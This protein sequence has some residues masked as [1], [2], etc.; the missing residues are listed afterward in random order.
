MR[1]VEISLKE[2]LVYILYKWIPIL[3][4]GVIIASFIGGYI[5]LKI[6][7][8]EALERIKEDNQKIVAENEAEILATNAKIAELEQYIKNIQSLSSFSNKKIAKVVADVSFDPITT[9]IARIR[10]GYTSLFRSMNLQ[11]TLSGLIPAD[12]SDDHLRLLIKVSIKSDAKSPNI[13][14]ITSLGGDGFDAQAVVEKVFEYFTQ[15]HADRLNTNGEHSLTISNISL[16]DAKDKQTLFDDEIKK[17]QNTINELKGAVSYYK[18]IIKETRQ[19]EGTS[20]SSLFKPVTFGFVLGI[21]LGIV[22]VALTYVIRL[23]LVI[24]EQVQERLK[25]RYIGGL[26]YRPALTIGKLAEVAA[27]G[28]LFFK[29]KG[30]AIDYIAVN[31]SEMISENS[32]LLVTGSVSSE[33]LTSFSDDLVDTGKLSDSIKV[34][35]S[36]DITTTADGID[37]LLQTDYVVLVERLGK[38]TLKRVKHQSDRIALSGKS[39][40]GYVLY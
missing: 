16:D 22:I 28:F 2:I 19:L 37:K 40:M 14:T 5:F 30:E 27:G 24:P 20:L 8:G 10:S 35:V 34:I 31:L 18:D 6:P 29:H 39:L 7:R 11:N 3:L 4:C 38:S 32:T 1:S 15:Q 23:V 21:V 12:Y 9:D 25:I 13:L 36:Q 33:V 26:N 17:Q